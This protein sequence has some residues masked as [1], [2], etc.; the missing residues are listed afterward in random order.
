MI[1]SSDSERDL[2]SDYMTVLKPQLESLVFQGEDG[3]QG[4]QFQSGF[5]VVDQSNRTKYHRY[6][7]MIRY[8]KRQLETDIIV[9]Y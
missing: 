4:I 5:L 2:K 8:L 6:K 3:V 9:E 1:L 7:E